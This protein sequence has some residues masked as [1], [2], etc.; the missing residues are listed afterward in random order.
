MTTA[1]ATVASLIAHGIDTM[2]ALPGVHNDYLF[3]ALFKAS[4]AIRVV[5]SRHEQGAAYMALGAALATNKPQ[6]YAVVPGPGLLNTGAAL[7]TAYSM[8]APVLA[9]IGQIPDADIGRGV[10]HLHEIRDQAGIIARLVDFTDRMRGPDT[11][12]ELVAQALRS[13]GT[14]RPGPAAL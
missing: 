2:Y 5:H 9:L 6:P 14:G 10:G 3:D 8:N 7:L 13:M 12:F 11:A 4:D 1:E